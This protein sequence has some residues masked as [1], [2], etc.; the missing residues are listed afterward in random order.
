VT[1]CAVTALSP[2]PIAF[3]AW[4]AAWD[5]ILGGCCCV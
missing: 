2:W 3:S 4:R 1:F 5:I